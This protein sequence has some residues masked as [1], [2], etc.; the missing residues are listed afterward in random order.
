MKKANVVVVGSSN[1][2]MIIQMKSI[3]RPG[4]TLLGGRFSIAPGGK[5]ANQ[6]VAAAR[7]A[8]PGGKVTFVA[9]VGQD[10]FGDQTIAG[11]KK[12]KISTDYVFRD[13]KNASGVALI[14]V[15]EDGE[16]SIGVAS[17]ANG[18]LSPADV[19]KAAKVIAESDI[20]VMQLETPLPTVLEA[21]KTA[22]KAGVPVILNPAPMQPLPEELLRK[23]TILTPNET[24]AESLTG[25]TVTDKKTA[26]EAASIL[27]RKGVPIVIITMG[28]KG[29]YL[30]A[31]ECKKM[32]KSFK[33]KAVDST[34]AGD[35]FNGALATALSQE[36]GLLEAIR[37]AIAAAAISVTRLGA[38]PSV[39]TRKEIEKMLKS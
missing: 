19:K 20:L 9:K 31:P 1:T 37:F 28:A 24:E 6:A 7:A 11:L 35:V 36:I 32:I 39:P 21:A 12:D 30:S 26:E 27:H 8:G 22:D 5:G 15:A 16:N 14:Y 2:D 25:I 33:V 23:V 29:V 3:P 17:G 10:L 38:Q 13:K 18:A 34:A 4:E